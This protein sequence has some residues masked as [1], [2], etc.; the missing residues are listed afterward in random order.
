MQSKLLLQM[1]SRLLLHTFDLFILNVI[2][3]VTLGIYFSTLP[4]PFSDLNSASLARVVTISLDLA[5]I[6]HT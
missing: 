3:V 4:H 1:W 5:T 6:C 2:P